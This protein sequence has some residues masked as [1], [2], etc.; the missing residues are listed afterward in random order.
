MFFFM[1]LA[2]PF[3]TSYHFLEDAYK[4]HREH[5]KSMTQQLQDKRKMIEEVSN[6]INNRYVLGM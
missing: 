6:T 3:S 1:E 4:H 2:F 5:V